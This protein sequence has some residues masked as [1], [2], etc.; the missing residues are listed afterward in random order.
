MDHY[1]YT[2]ADPRDGAVFYVGK[3]QRDRMHQHE[4]MAKK[5]RVCGNY[6]KF[7]RLRE[8]LLAG[9][10]V[11]ADVVARFRTAEEAFS[12]ERVLI[13]EI[14]LHNLTNITPGGGGQAPVN[15]GAAEARLAARREAKTL[16]WLRAWLAQVDTW[17]HGVTFPGLAD[18]D[19][20]AEEFVT[21]VRQM[22][23]ARANI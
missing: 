23:T 21:M 9:L 1:V 15:P 6:P 16:G 4:I 8:I 19:A 17:A 5:G 14:G 22:V 7:C 3:G 2:L 10:S 11:K 12:H 18:G 20:K 13:A